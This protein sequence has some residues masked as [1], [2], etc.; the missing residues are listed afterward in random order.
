[1]K[2][3]FLKDYYQKHRAK[4]WFNNTNVFPE[5]PCQEHVLL[6]AIFENA[7]K[8]GMKIKDQMCQA[9]SNNLTYGIL[10]GRPWAIL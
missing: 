10:A 8:L 1:M 9:G 7:R 3:R 2:G 6:L 4:V 5:L